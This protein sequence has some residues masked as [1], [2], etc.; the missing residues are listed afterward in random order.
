[1][2]SSLGSGISRVLQAPRSWWSS[3]SHWSSFQLHVGQPVPFH[4]RMDAGEEGWCE[5]ACT[6]TPV[7]WWWCFH[8]GQ[9]TGGEWS[10]FCTK[11]AMFKTS[12]QS[13]IQAIK[14]MKHSCLLLSRVSPMSFHRPLLSEGKQDP[15]SLRGFLFRSFPEAPANWEQMISCFL[16]SFFSLKRDGKVR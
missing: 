16:F 15:W 10:S 8:D 2:G 1:M 11:S 4:R 12:E 14:Y 7:L 9:V 5:Q 3:G 6:G 13:Q